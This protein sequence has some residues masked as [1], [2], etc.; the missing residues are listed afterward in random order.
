MIDLKDYE[1]K[2][3][4]REGE[5]GITEK[6]IDVI[7]GENKYNKTYVEFGVESGMEC[8][9]RILREKYNWSG[10]MMDGGYENIRINLRREFI[11]KENIISLFQ[12]YN[13]PKHIHLFCLDIDFNDFY[14]LHEVLKH[15]TFDILIIEYNAIHNYN[16]DKIV[17]Y[18]PRRMWDG[19]SSFF[20]ASLSA[21]HKLCNNFNY[22]L[23]YCENIGANA[24]FINNNILSN[25]ND[26]F[27]NCNNIKE[28]Y[29]KP[30]YPTGP[31]MGPNKSLK[32]EY[33]TYDEAIKY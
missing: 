11:T 13:L 27:I 24:Y 25:I 12:K 14:V 20:G 33:I 19:Y 1:K 9:T 2:I 6:V 21:F 8:N 4:S 28:L 32:Y 23:V 26:T 22:S 16:E 18:D 31:N 3:Y 10:L 29:K 15:Y 17:K 5:D 30:G 7:Y